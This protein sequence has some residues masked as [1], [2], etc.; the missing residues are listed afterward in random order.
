MNFAFQFSKL[1]M[2]DIAAPANCDDAVVA[3]PDDQLPFGAACVLPRDIQSILFHYGI[4]R[5]EVDKL[6]DEGVESREMFNEANPDG[7]GEQERAFNLTVQAMK[8]KPVRLSRLRRAFR[9][10]L[11]SD[12]MVAIVAA[13]P[14]VPIEFG[15]CFFYCFWLNGN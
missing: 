4:S 6:I 8:L 3:L 14:Q 9:R 13:A 15:A 1:D 2:P 5:V 7:D 11:A 10:V 12:P